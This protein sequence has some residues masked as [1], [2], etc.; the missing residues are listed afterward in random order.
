MVETGGARKASQGNL[1]GYLAGG[2]DKADW[3]GHA[4]GERTGSEIDGVGGKENGYYGTE[5]GDTQVV[6]GTR[7]GAVEVV[8]AS[9][10]DG[11]EG[12]ETGGRGK[13]DRKVRQR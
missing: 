4:V 1:G 10:Y 11:G 13:I 7:A 8:G 6:I 12:V 9:V 2:Q 3:E 5:T